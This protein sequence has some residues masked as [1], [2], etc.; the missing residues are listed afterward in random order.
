[1]A[2]AKCP[3]CQ[4]Q[5]EC[6][7]AG[8]TKHVRS[9]GKKTQ[10]QKQKPKKQRIVLPVIGEA[11]SLPF[12]L[13]LP[14]KLSSQNK[15]QW[16]HWS[17]AMKDKS[18]WSNYL[19]HMLGPLQGRMYC[20]SSWRITRFYSGRQKE[21]DLANLIGGAKPIP[22]ILQEFGVIVDDKPSNFSCSYEQIKTH[23]PADEKVRTR[24]T[25]LEVANASPQ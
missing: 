13:D 16:A 24:I 18:R 10:T 15:T 20:W 8:I 4:I 11:P 14:L 17:V 1:M 5:L 23:D 21:M 3:T 9:C 7:L 6:T 19:A 12:N 25:L 2:K 22:D